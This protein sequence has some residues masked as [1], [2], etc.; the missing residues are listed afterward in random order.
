MKQKIAASTIDLSKSYYDNYIANRYAGA[1]QG[2]RLKR[3]MR[4][5]YRTTAVSI[6][7]LES[8]DAV[9]IKSY[10]QAVFNGNSP[11]CILEKVEKT[12]VKG[13]DDTGKELSRFGKK[14]G[15]KKPW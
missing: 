10:V 5:N 4:K 8:Y 1:M 14:I 11:D 7:A 9:D 3:A 12:I 13:F 15:I 2:A 6:G